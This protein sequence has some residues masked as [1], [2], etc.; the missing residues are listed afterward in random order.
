MVPVL[1]NISLDLIYFTPSSLH[2][3]IPYSPVALTLFPLPTGNH[4]FI[5][6]IYESLFYYIHK[7][8]PVF[9]FHITVISYSIG[10]FVTYKHNTSS[11]QWFLSPSMLLWWQ[12]FILF[13]GWAVFHC[14]CTTSS[15]SIHLLVTQSESLSWYYE[16][17]CCEQWGAC[18]LLN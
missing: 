9:R 8:V 5:F 13:N 12:K 3:L 4:Y 7:F 2:L 11:A 16:K 15:L 17:C 1:Y 14:V 6:H 10:F 18:Y